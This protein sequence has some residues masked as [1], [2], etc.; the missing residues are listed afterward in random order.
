MDYIDHLLKPKLTAVNI[1]S[2]TDMQ[3]VLQP[4][5]RG[6]GHTIGNSMR[7]TLL[8]AILGAAITE[9]KIEGVQHEYMA[10]EGVEE[11]VMDIILNLKEVCVIL[12]GSKNHV[13]AKINKKGKGAVTASDID[14]GADIEI[15]NKD[16]VIANLGDKGELNI[17]LVIM[18]GFGY[19]SVT[20]RQKLSDGGR[21][22]G[23]DSL[24]ID[25][26]FSPV[27]KVSYSVESAR[28]GDRSDLDK[29]IMEIET[30]GTLD[31]E[32]LIKQAATLLHSQLSVFVDFDQTNT[33]E[34]EK[35]R[36]A[37]NAILRRPIDDLELTVRSTNCLK[38]EKIYYIGDLVQCS[39]RTLL[40]TPNLGR[41]SLNEIKEVLAV[42]DLDLEMEIENWPPSDLPP[43]SSPFGGK[44]I[45]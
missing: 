19:Q 21:L 18:K 4:F 45:K 44:Y 32:S 30:N 17:E 28:V 40:R 2:D 5:E 9:V 7:R 43:T 16:H 6:F 37:F 24:L 41:K 14:G 34:E 13:V 33:V 11:D 1:L 35:E 20:E 12:H 23:A 39:E 10:I 26:S 22:L 27:N 31:A 42:H 36:A 8:S 3:V 15:S 38:T 25:A 29:L